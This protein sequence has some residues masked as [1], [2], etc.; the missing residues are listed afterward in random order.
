MKT[1]NQIKTNILYFGDDY[2]P[3]AQWAMHN[4][5]INDDTNQFLT[6]QEMIRELRNI[7]ENDWAQFDHACWDVATKENSYD[8]Y[9]ALFGNEGL[10]FQEVPSQENPVPEEPTSPTPL[11]E[12]SPRAI[13][14]ALNRNPNADG[15]NV[16]ILKERGVT[17]ESVRGKITTIPDDVLEFALNP[18]NNHREIF[19]GKLP[20]DHNLKDCV[21]IYFWGIPRAGKTSI[22]ASLLSYCRSEGYVNWADNA[23]NVPGYNYFNALSGS[24]IRNPAWVPQPT[25]HGGCQYMMLCNPSNQKTKFVFFDVAGELVVDL[26]PQIKSEKLNL[27][28]GFDHYLHD[29]NPKFHFFVYD[30]SDNFI[31][32]LG[33]SQ[34]VYIDCLRQHFEETEAFKKKNTIGFAFIAAK[35]DLLSSSEKPED[36]IVKN[37]ASFLGMIEHTARKYGIIRGKESLPVIPYSIGDVYMSGVCK[38]NQE[39]PMSLWTYI[40]KKILGFEL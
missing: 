8:R 1:L 15:Y 12:Y 37:S 14:D 17:Y 28:E 16:D 22:L 29:P 27:W 34:S 19:P 3:I 35:S 26:H 25:P 32:D 21:E 40:A 9:I 38:P 7:I 13:A 31:D 30:V 39:Y 6:P 11:D 18:K 36:V 23:N 20:T 10:H 33:L 24:M 5:I 4:E 2:T